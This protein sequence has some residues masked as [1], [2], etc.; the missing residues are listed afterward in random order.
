MWDKLHQPGAVHCGPGAPLHLRGLQLRPA[1][2]VAV[3]G[4]RAA[5]AY[6]VKGLLFFKV[7]CACVSLPLPGRRCAP[8]QEVTAT[9]QPCRRHAVP[10]A[11]A[12][13]GVAAKRRWY[14]DGNRIAEGVVQDEQAEQDGHH[15]RVCNGQELANRQNA[16]GWSAGFGDTRVVPARLPFW[17]YQRL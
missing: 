9:C 3:V 16:S 15:V 2:P 11:E 8:Q 5:T 12:Q 17:R 13:Q 4:G 7:H 1:L 10:A 6:T 14:Q